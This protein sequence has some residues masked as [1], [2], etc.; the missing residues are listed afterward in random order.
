MALRDVFAYRSAVH[1]GSDALLAAQPIEFKPD[2]TAA[3]V[4]QFVEMLD[5]FSRA[6]A[7]GAPITSRDVEEN[8][9]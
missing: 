4:R 9:L 7:R 5:L 6:A 3:E 2:A 1:A 8:E